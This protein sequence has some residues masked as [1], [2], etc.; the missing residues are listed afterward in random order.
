MGFFQSLKERFQRD[1][2]VKRG[3]TRVG[4]A[5]GGAAAYVGSK[6]KEAYLRRYGGGEYREA[7]IQELREKQRE[8][9]ARASLSKATS[10]ARRRRADSFRN[11]LGVPPA[12]RSVRR[13]AGYRRGRPRD[14]S[15]RNGTQPPEA[16]NDYSFITGRGRAMNED[17]ITGRKAQD[18]NDY[19]R[20]KRNF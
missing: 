16:Q 19:V 6:A 5:V 12:P 13:D 1:D 14:G 9:Q 15:L 3:A 17:Y 18:I 11:F 7:R 4:Q 10:E 20:R 2:S 8:A